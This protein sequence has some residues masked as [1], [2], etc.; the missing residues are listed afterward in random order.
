MYVVKNS[1]SSYIGL[2]LSLFKITLMKKI[3]SNNNPDH[4]LEILM[5]R[6]KFHDY[7]SSAFIKLPILHERKRSLYV[8]F[9]FK[10]C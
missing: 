9:F 10:L 3:D 1:A 5:K 2:H 8:L 7:L 6:F 4:Q